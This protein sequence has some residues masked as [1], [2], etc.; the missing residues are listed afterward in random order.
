[1]VSIMNGERG[2]EAIK[3]AAMQVVQLQATHAALLSGQ[4]VDV[5]TLASAI[6]PFQAAR[7][8]FVKLPQSAYKQAPFVRIKPAGQY[9]C[10]K[11]IQHTNFC[12]IGVSV[13]EETGRVVIITAI[14]NLVKGAAGQAV[15]NMNIRFGFPEEAGLLY[16]CL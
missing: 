14:D 9:P 10:L 16:P 12:D 7:A 3:A 11:D 1:M 15:Q 13:H 2:F 5:Q 4:T 6:S 8:L